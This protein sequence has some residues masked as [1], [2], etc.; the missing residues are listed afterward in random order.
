MTVS[1]A[2]SLWQGL[3]HLIMP[4]VCLACHELLS[5]ERNDF[6]SECDRLFGADPN[7]TCPRCSSTVGPHSDLTDGCNQCRGESFAFDRAMRLGPYEGRLREL[8]LRLKAPGSEGLSEAVGERFAEQVCPKFGTIRIDLVVPV[9]L[10]WRR[11]WQRGFNQCDLLARAIACR[12]GRPCHPGWLRRV[13]YTE[14][15][16]SLSPTA[17][18]DNVK[19]AFRTT[20]WARMRDQHVLLVDDVLTTGSTAHEAARALRNAGATSV[21]VAVLAHGH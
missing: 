8:I 5:P 7:P 11:R 3:R 6:C 12:L 4:G 20:A 10:H 13:R 14:M 9:P 17:R 2:T 18:R 1:F 19:R 15:Q 21:S 16:S